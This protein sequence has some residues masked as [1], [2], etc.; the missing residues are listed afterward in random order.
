MAR[1]PDPEDFRGGP[2]AVGT[3]GTGRTLPSR[4]LPLPLRVPTSPRHGGG[5]YF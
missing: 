4:V 3:R 1:P 5:D 2:T